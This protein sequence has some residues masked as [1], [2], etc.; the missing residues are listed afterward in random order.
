MV[1]HKIYGQKQ[2][3][4]FK[5]EVRTL[6]NKRQKSSKIRRTSKRKTTGNKIYR[7]R[8]KKEWR[9]KDK[10]NV[11]DRDKE[12]KEKKVNSVAKINLDEKL[13]PM[14][15]INVGDITITTLLD[16]GSQCSIVEEETFELI[17]DKTKVN[18]VSRMVRLRSF[19]GENI[20]FSK[21]VRFSFKIGTKT[22]SNIFYI[23]NQTLTEDYKMILGMDFM[24]A[25]KVTLD[26]DN[27]QLIMHGDQ[28]GRNNIRINNV[29]VNL[30]KKEHELKIYV[31]NFEEHENQM[32]K[33][34]NEEINNQKNVITTQATK[35]KQGKENFAR[36]INRIELTPEEKRDVNLRL[37]KTLI[38]HM[39]NI[40]DSGKNLLHSNTIIWD[41]KDNKQIKVAIQNGT[42]KTIVLN[43]GMKIAKIQQ[44]DKQKIN[45]NTK[46]SGIENKETREVEYTDE[47]NFNE[48]IQ[49]ENQ[50]INSILQVENKIKLPNYDEVM[51]LREQEFN[52]TDFDLKHLQP[53]SKKEFSNLLEKYYGVFSKSY[54]TLGWTTAIK[55]K[56]ELLHNYPIQ[57]KPYPLPKHLEPIAK[58]E[59]EELREA[60]ILEDTNSLYAF[61]VIFVSKKSE[62]GKEKK[63]RMATDFRLLNYNTQLIK[64]F[65]PTIKDLIHDIAGYKYYTTVDLKAAFFQIVLPQSEREKCALVSP[66]GNLQPTRLSFGLKNSSAYFIQLMQLV[67]RDIMS[68]EISF[69]VDDVIIAANSLDKLHQNME[70]VFKCFLDFNLTIDPKKVKIAKQEIEILGFKITQEGIFPANDNIIKITKFKT[71]QSVKEI[72]SFL[73]M[74]NYF[75]HLIPNYSELVA[76]LIKLTRKNSQFIWSEECRD[77]FAK[78]Q[79][80]MLEQPKINKIDPEKKLVVLITDGAKHAISA[81]L[82]QEVNGKIQPCLYFSKLLK[83]AQKRYPQVKIE[84]LAIY[85]AFK[86]FHQH[87]ANTHFIL[88]TDAKSLRYHFD[89]QKQSDVIAR[90]LLTM[91]QY[92]FTLRHISGP[93]NPSD[94]F[95][96]YAINSITMTG[97]THKIFAGNEKLRFT[98]IAK[99]QDKDDNL[100]LIKNKVRESGKNNFENYYLNRFNTLRYKVYEKGVFKFDTIVVPTSLEELVMQTVHATHLGFDKCLHIMKKHYTF[101]VMYSKLKNFVNTCEACCKYKS[102]PLAKAPAEENLRGLYPGQVLQIDIVG[103]L[104]RSNLGNI[105]VLTVIDVFSRHFEAYPLKNVESKTILNKLLDYFTTYGVPTTIMSDNGKYFRSG[106]FHAVLKNLNIDIRHSSIYKASTQGV[107]ER[108]HRTIFQAVRTCA[109]GSFNWESN[110]RFVKLFYNSTKHSMLGLPPNLLFFSR[111]VNLPIIDMG[112][113]EEL[114]DF[115]QL[116]E[117][118]WNNFTRREFQKRVQEFSKNRK[119]AVLFQTQKQLEM[120]QNETKVKVREIKV[121]DRVFVKK[122]VKEGKFDQRFTGPYRVEKTVRHNNV[123]LREI[124]KPEKP[125]IKVH[126]NHVFRVPKEKY[127]SDEK[128]GE[129]MNEEDQNIQTNKTVQHGKPG[130]KETKGYKA[131]RIPQNEQGDPKKKQISKIENRTKNGQ[132][133]NQKDSLNKEEIFN[134]IK[135][136]NEIRNK[137]IRGKQIKI[138][139]QNNKNEQRNH[140]NYDIENNQNSRYN[141]RNRN[142]QRRYKY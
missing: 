19:T 117:A 57:C 6:R 64:V 61:P 106:E 120:I 63:F 41:K 31:E 135:E 22:F 50:K 1:P 89:L 16:T 44:N 99:E 13:T 109:E 21:A 90:W 119:L 79:Q 103:K 100:K 14:I 95:S 2:N 101:P 60:G 136:K 102:R 9:K 17:K 132:A 69:Y 134:K 25:F 121:G 28:V 70:K 78:L 11:K 94:Y 76:P 107:I 81:I 92:D 46:E 42:D 27:A 10:I 114:G 75:S 39:V 67:L 73:G 140:R 122:F 139:E 88:Q 4:F 65:S 83:D 85:Q 112:P 40:V 47:I 142:G 36:L 126:K 3:K 37:D 24:N 96:R 141:F 115:F 66:F 131:T 35:N 111:E 43:K 49:G 33:I 72:Q 51:H 97:V 26:I 80:I 116:E 110:L 129:E 104:P 55:P 58:K 52:I 30:I 18:Y 29:K 98:N 45:K 56:I 130:D 137:Q 118:E 124:Q 125:T 82:G 15:N 68:K 127:N 71:P 59:I 93:T 113:F 105:F 62:D 74:T 8:Y 20:A 7:D 108:S 5:E 53:G 91:S 54:K 123:I 77:N 34:E 23:T 12:S 84:L 48:S 133:E 32:E 128:G 87:L 38:D 86:Y 138:A